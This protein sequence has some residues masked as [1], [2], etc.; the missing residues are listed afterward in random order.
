M[1]A[2]APSGSESVDK[3]CTTQL[4]LHREAAPMKLTGDERGQCGSGDGRERATTTS[5]TARTAAATT[6]EGRSWSVGTSG[7]EVSGDHSGV[8]LFPGGRDA[9]TNAVDGQP[10]NKVPSGRCRSDAG[11]VSHSAACIPLPIS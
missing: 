4:S 7:E 3:A 8:P 11:I 9:A 10:T 1:V 5:P 6:I 2:A